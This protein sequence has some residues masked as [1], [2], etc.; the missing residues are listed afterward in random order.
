M[1]IWL[2][3]LAGDLRYALRVLR[4]S[5]VF[6]AV[7]VLSL[8]LGIGAN[9]TIFS[10]VN[11]ALLRPLPVRE[12]DRLIRV[13]R[14]SEDRPGSISYPLFEV[15]R[16][17]LT[18]I[19]GSLATMTMEQPIAMDGEEDIVSTEL[20]SGGYFAVPRSVLFGVT[21]ADP[22][23]FAVAA[24]TLAAAA[25]VAGWLPARAASRLDPLSALRHE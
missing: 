1:K 16:D 21:P 18:S 10:L 3:D 8:A 13:M 11:A 19:S 20:V 5:P 25:L 2:A 22:R 14:M 24:L 6:T 15:F 12:P 23:V 17:R 7:A 9:A 4:R